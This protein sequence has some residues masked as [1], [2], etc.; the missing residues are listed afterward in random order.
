VAS[1]AWGVFH[2]SFLVLNSSPA[3]R[4]GPIRKRPH[5][6]RLLALEMYRRNKI[7]LGR[8]AEPCPTPLAALMDFAA[9]HGVPPSRYSDEELKPE[10]RI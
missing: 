8:A 3:Q 1:A 5:L 2:S 7:S 9:K 10:R 4:L 6:N